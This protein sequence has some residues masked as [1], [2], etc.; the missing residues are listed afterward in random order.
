MSENITALLRNHRAG[1]RAAFDRLMP[2]VYDQLCVVARRQLRRMQPRHTLDTSAL[3]REAYLQL[4][5]EAGVEWQ[6]R[7]HLLAICARTM[8]RVLV[9]AARHRQA[10]KRNGGVP[11]ASIDIETL[12]ADEQ[13]ELMLVI[14][15]ALERLAQFNT[16][17]AQVVECRFFAGMTEDETALALDLSLRVVQRDWMRARVWLQ[18][19]LG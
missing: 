9:D 16:R 13:H 14:D 5:E 2:L 12:A 11:A 18:K 7:G 6:D 17:L 8:R 10:A 15:D 19:A 3:V 4:V 1:D